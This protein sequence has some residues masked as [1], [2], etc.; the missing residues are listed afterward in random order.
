MSSNRYYDEI[1]EDENGTLRLAVS[2][3]D[4]SSLQPFL[5]SFGFSNV[6]TDV[7]SGLTELTF[8]ADVDRNYLRTILMRYAQE[9]PPSSE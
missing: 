4:L 7:G 5:K 1:Q 6:A 8:A 3:N 9:N 2:D